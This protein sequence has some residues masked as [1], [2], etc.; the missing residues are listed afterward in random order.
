MNHFSNCISAFLEN[1]TNSLDED[2][3]IM[4]T[5]PKE[6]TDGIG[7]GSAINSNPLSNRTIVNGDSDIKN[8]GSE[9]NTT[10]TSPSEFINNISTSSIKINQAKANNGREN[11]TNTRTSITNV[12]NA[13]L[14]R[15]HSTESD[16]M[17]KEIISA[18]STSTAFNVTGNLPLAN[19]TI[20]IDSIVN[21]TSLAL[22]TTLNEGITNS[23]TL[24]GGVTI[25]SSLTNSGSQLTATT[26]VGNFKLS[27]NLINKTFN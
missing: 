10:L 23:E 17:A 11:I 1:E 26:P 22:T 19:D 2:T 8:G 14:L 20:F 12:T 6:R 24:A 15:Y 9:S 16:S 3:G 7:N 27:Y 18:T 5:D 21:L 25:I 13:S 4:A